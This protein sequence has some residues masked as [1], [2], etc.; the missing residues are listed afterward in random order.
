M[1][2][3]DQ[4]N[5]NIVMGGKNIYGVSLG[6]LMLDTRFPRIAGDVG[7]ASTWSF[8]V[9]Y[10][11]VKGASPDKV[12]NKSAEGL[13]DAFIDAGRELIDMGV[14]GISTNCGF[15]CLHQQKMAAALDVPVVSSSLMQ[16]PMIQATLAPGKR[17]GILTISSASLTT[18]HLSAVN[19]PLDTPIMG[20]EQGKEFTNAMLN[21][22]LYLDFKQAEADILEA[23]KLFVEKHPELGAIVL[24]CTNMVPYAAKLQ[25]TLGVPVYSIYSFLN[26]FQSGLS[27]RQFD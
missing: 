20:T 24:E 18:K 11:I 1:K 23:G 26:W 19:V 8:P 17:V 7:Y 15:M 6:I 9:H 21:D 12:V 5:Q 25:Q 14:S 27:P 16:I 22:E 2:T 10:K 13:L 4:N 3:N